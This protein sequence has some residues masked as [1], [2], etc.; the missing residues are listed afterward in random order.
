MNE[1]DQCK[2]F[3][4]ILP[5]KC[6]KTQNP[7]KIAYHLAWNFRNKFE[8]NVKPNDKQFK[9]WYCIFEI[10]SGEIL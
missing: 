5:G 1:N 7:F 4:K 2:K 8:I 3:Y 10:F 9:K 6:S